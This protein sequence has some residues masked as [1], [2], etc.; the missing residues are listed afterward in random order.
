MW[1]IDVNS[2]RRRPL[3]AVYTTDQNPI[4]KTYIRKGLRMMPVGSYKKRN[5]LTRWYQKICHD[6][7]IFLQW[8]EWGV[9]LHVVRNVPWSP[10]ARAGQLCGENI[11]KRIWQL[12]YPNVSW[13]LSIRLKS[14]QASSFESFQ[15][16]F[17]QVGSSLAV[18]STKHCQS[19][20]DN[21]TRT[22]APWRHTR[23]VYNAKPRAHGEISI[24][25]LRMLNHKVIGWLWFVQIL[26]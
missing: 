21:C 24:R 8:H 18:M 6:D 2:C 3:K 14:G 26:E 9:L 1:C 13:T 23:Q 15:H 11:A 7:K 22:F 10:T 19:I 20:P 12:L 4:L 5:V 25:F 17:K 16:S